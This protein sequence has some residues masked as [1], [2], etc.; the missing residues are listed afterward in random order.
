MKYEVFLAF[1]NSL[2]VFRPDCQEV[3]FISQLNSFYNF[4]HNIF[5]LDSSVDSS[6]FININTPE[7]GRI[8]CFTNT[9][10][11]GYTPQTLYFFKSVDDKITG[12]EALKQINS[13]N[14]FIIVVPESVR[15]ERNIQLLTH[16][17]GLQRLKSN[18]KIGVLITESPAT[19][20][21][22]KLFTWT[23]KHSIINIFI[24][25]FSAPT[26]VSTIENFPNIFTFNPFGALDV[27]KVNG[28]GSL[29]NLFLTQKSNFQQ[30]QLRVGGSTPTKTYVNEKLWRCVFDVLNA[31]YTALKG[32][33][34]NFGSIPRARLFENNTMDIVMSVYPDNQFFSQRKI[35]LYPIKMEE[36][37]VVQNLR[38][39]YKLQHRTYFLSTS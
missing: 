18:M 37:V 25:F 32:Y 16:I 7:Q 14:T 9:P 8:S 29:S 39:T 12:L 17:K 36:Y 4:D 21:L 27:I 23:W 6:R 33:E 5:L 31:S 28:S 26:R 2:S 13:K 19:D 11:Q 34:F 35:N 20:D 24:A 3:I 1:I 15:F 22:Q 38:L 10:S 30:Y